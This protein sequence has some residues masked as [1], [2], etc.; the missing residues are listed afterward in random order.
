MAQQAPLS[1]AMG[2]SAYK[3]A[4]T[5]GCREFTQKRSQSL[6]SG[7]GITDM[8]LQ[9]LLLYCSSQE[10]GLRLAQI[11]MLQIWL[12]FLA[13]GMATSANTYMIQ[14]P[15]PMLACKDLV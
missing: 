8:E 13:P 12:R 1:M 4:E 7:G 3:G 10:G 6:R 2:S 14:I 15:V 11:E 9:S 5:S